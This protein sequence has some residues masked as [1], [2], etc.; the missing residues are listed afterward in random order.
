M[1]LRRIGYAIS[2][3][4]IILFA[5]EWGLFVNWTEKLKTKCDINT[6]RHY[7]PQK[8]T[9]RRTNRQTRVVQIWF[10]PLVFKYTFFWI[11]GEKQSKKSV[12]AFSWNWNF[13]EKLSWT[14]MVARYVR[15]TS[16]NAISHLLC[17]W[18]VFT[19]F[20][21]IFQMFGRNDQNQNR[22]TIYTLK[23][24]H[25]H[26][27]S[28]D[29]ENVVCKRFHA[30]LRTVVAIIAAE[31]EKEREKGRRASIFSSSSSSSSKT[32]QSNHI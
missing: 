9:D 15:S 26:Y 22:I 12:L 16:A 25:R 10:S 30:V 14:L 11:L 4:L 32:R 3:L 20:L 8:E 18:E 13:P 17:L 1:F 24:T 7:T 23:H 29:D 6:P 2:L 27:H 5:G 19:Y 28:M 21:N 31:I